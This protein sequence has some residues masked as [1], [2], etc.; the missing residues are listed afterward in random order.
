MS[1]C[2]V[3]LI[4]LSVFTLNTARNFLQLIVIQVRQCFVIDL[5]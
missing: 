3:L 1:T 5:L 2:L 4:A